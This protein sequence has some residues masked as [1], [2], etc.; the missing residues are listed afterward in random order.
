MA[1]AI[2]VVICGDGAIGK[3]C[4]L[5]TVYG[6]EVT[7]WDNPEY[8]PTAASNTVQTWDIDGMGEAHF[9]FWDTAGQEALKSLRAE[10]YPGTQIL[11]IGFDMTNTDSLTNIVDNWIG[12]FKEYCAECHAIIVVGTKSDLFAERGGFEGD[13]G[14]KREEVMKV[15]IEIGAAAVV[16]TSA[17][18]RDGVVPDAEP[19]FTN[20]DDGA[21]LNSLIKGL[22]KSLFDNKNIP[23]V[24]DINAGGAPAP[25]PAPGPVAAGPAPGPP[26]PAP[27]VKAKDDGCCTIF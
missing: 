9:E 21:H 10:A 13:G 18:T 16:M 20:S 15:A 6:T 8:Q 12:E 23:I 14:V 17:K 5:D 22:A 3:T 4:L 25:A 1:S 2:K 24:V 11:L 7:D 19:D 27:G 26:A